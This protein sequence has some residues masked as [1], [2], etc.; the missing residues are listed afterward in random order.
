VESRLYILLAAAFSLCTGCG[1]NAM[2]STPDM[3]S[4]PVALATTSVTT[5]EFTLRSARYGV[6]LFH[7]EPCSVI[8]H[9]TNDPMPYP[10]QVACDVSVT[11]RRGFIGGPVLFQ[12]RTTTAGLM[13]FGSSEA[14]YDLGYFESALGGKLVMVVSNMPNQHDDSVCHSRVDVIELLPK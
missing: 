9:H 7:Q 3:S 8:Q 13:R 12:Q 4:T 5:N 6:Y 2:W 14:R 1:R 10:K 11:I